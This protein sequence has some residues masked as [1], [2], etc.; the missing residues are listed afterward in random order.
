MCG[1]Q[2]ATRLECHGARVHSCEPSAS[3]ERIRRSRCRSAS[4]L[5]MN[6]SSGKLAPSFPRQLPAWKKPGAM[7]TL[8]SKSHQRAPDTVK[9]LCGSFLRA[10]GTRYH[11]DTRRLNKKK[12]SLTLS[13]DIVTRQPSLTAKAQYPTSSPKSHHYVAKS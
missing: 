2:D 4:H 1:N 3:A 12:A 10:H 8:S 7:K 9:G 11:L 5:K 13:P 6:H